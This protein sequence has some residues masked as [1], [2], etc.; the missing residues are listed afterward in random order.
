MAM[1]K[2]GSAIIAEPSITTE[3]WQENLKTWKVECDKNGCRVKTAKNVIAKYS[4]EKYL[5]SHATIIAAVDVDEA[6]ESKGPYKDYLI[7]PE[8][9]KLINN[10]GDAWTKKML[11]TCYKTFIGA[12]NYLEHVQIPELKKGK[13]IDA[14]LREVPIGKDIEGK[15]LSTF[16]VDILVATE[17][18]HKELV[19]KIESKQLTTLSMGCRISFSLCSKCGNKAIDDTETCDHIRYEKNNTFYDE[20]GIQRKVAELCGYHSE[21]DSVTFIDASWVVNPAFTGAVIRNT[22]DPPENVMAKIYEA[23]QKEGYTFNEKDFLKVAAR[24]ILAQED[25][26]KEPSPPTEGPEEEAPA[27]DDPAGEPEK[28]KV[29]EEEPAEDLEAPTGEPEPPLEQN[30]VK[31][32]KDKI[33]KRLLQE[34][35]DEIADE[36]EGEEDMGPRELSTLDENLIQPTASVVLKQL[37]KSKKLSNMYLQNKVR[38]LNKKSIDKLRFGSYML[39]TSNDPTVLSNYGYNRRDFLAV[40]S[41]I[42]GFFKKPLALDLKKAVA[43]L[44]SPKGLSLNKAAYAL[45]KLAGRKL[46]ID[47]LKK[48]LMWLKLMDSYT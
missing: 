33:K 43:I 28:E 16:Y 22:V 3:K 36:F 4:P 41:Y 30:S 12:N 20:N 25:T 1:M 24:E 2:Y 31:V 34:L 37:W 42:D 8:Y 27:E 5:L 15:E 23:E 6:R 7:K 17:R 18:K 44:E 35:G 39:L 26:D 21:P 11:A 38:N 46:A 10:N 40:M 47:E 14:V 48:A 13:V 32:W 45:S 19:K 9:S 29:P